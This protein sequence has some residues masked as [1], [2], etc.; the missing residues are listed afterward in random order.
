MR[1][2]FAALGSRVICETGSLIC[3]FTLCRPQAEWPIP[4][5][6]LSC[7]VTMTTSL[8]NGSSLDIQCRQRS[9]LHQGLQ[10]QVSSEQEKQ[11]K[12]LDQVNSFI[13][14]VFPR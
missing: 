11:G 10:F 12:V 4:P 5:L 14:D 1:V 7:L 6:E 13:P 9:S 8:R 2:S 3:H